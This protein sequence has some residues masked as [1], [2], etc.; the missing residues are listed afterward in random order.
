MPTLPAPINCPL[1]QPPP[2][3]NS[4]LKYF[5]IWSLCNNPR[6]QKL[7]FEKGLCHLM[8]R[9]W[10]LIPLSLRQINLAW[11]L[12]ILLNY[13]GPLIVQIQIIR[14][15]ILWSLHKLPR[16]L[17]KVQ[18][19]KAKTST[20]DRKL[21]WVIIFFSLCFVTFIKFCSSQLTNYY[22]RAAGGRSKM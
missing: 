1:N 5:F 21:T 11:F 6:V 18:F 2:P 10:Y 3:K 4:C 20:S 8:A 12:I 19:I 14:S 17:Y 13:R 22:Y 7:I 16:F 9:V 15:S